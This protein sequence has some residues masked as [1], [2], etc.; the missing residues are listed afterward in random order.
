MSDDTIHILAEEVSNVAITEET[1][2][3]QF[4]EETLV[5]G[6]VVE[7]TD[8]QVIEET[9]SLQLVEETTAVTDVEETTVHTFQEV[10]VQVVSEESMA[11]AKKIDWIDDNTFYKGEANPG[12]AAGASE[13]RIRYVT[14]AP[15]GDVEETWAEGNANFDNIWNDRASLSYS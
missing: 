15:D 6:V 5:N 14:I 8:V 13:W 7:T 9:T 4:V 12:T 3:V 1:T 11:Y 2:N 10:Q